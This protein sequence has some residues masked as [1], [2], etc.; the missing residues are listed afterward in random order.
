M[1]LRAQINDS[2]PA[3]LVF[4]RE[5][6]AYSFRLGD[7][8]PRTATVLPVEPGI[9]SVLVD[10]R[11]YDVK[12]VPG[13]GTWYVDIRGRH[14]AVRVEDPRDASAGSGAVAAQ[15]PQKIAAQMPG[16]VVR[17]LVGQGDQV[18]PGQGLVVVEAMKMQ[19]ELK[20]PRGGRIAT[21]LAREGSTVAAG[22][23]LATLE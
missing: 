1:K 23:V 22:E 2:E 21:L 20:A 13:Q 6:D 11:S 18:E 12:I 15:G 10:G 16:K 9:Y 14:L 7:V 19:N 8:P 5:G 3:E 4:T 17:V